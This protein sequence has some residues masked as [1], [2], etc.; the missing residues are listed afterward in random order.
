[1]NLGHFK[2][3]LIDLNF[4]TLTISHLPLGAPYSFSIMWKLNPNYYPK[5]A[6]CQSSQISILIGC[7]PSWT[8]NTIGVSFLAVA[9]LIPSIPQSLS[10]HHAL[11]QRRA[12]TK[13]LRINLCVDA[14]DVNVAL[15]EYTRRWER[16]AH[17]WQVDGNICP[18]AQRRDGFK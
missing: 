10:T 17:C 15:G 9:L 7:S 3:L 8:Q 2:F 12:F 11:Y 14:I 18:I 5:Q 16:E 13:L 1:M 4:V 6:V